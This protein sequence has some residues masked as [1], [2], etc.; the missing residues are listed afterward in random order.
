MHNFVEFWPLNAH[1]VCLNVENLHSQNGKYYA[2]IVFYSQ[3]S[4]IFPYFLHYY[5]TF[6]FLLYC[7][8]VKFDNEE[9]VLLNQL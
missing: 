9:V 2:L 1:P 6:C 8:F 4:T 7:I 5:F 3:F